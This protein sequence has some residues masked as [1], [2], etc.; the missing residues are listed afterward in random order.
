M[1]RNFFSSLNAHLHGLHE[2]LLCE[3][4]FMTVIALD[5]FHV[6][7][8]SEDDYQRSKNDQILSFILASFYF[9]FLNSILITI[10]FGSLT[11]IF[12]RFFSNASFVLILLASLIITGYFIRSFNIYLLP[13]DKFWIKF[14]TGLLLVINLVCILLWIWR[15]RKINSRRENENA[16][17]KYLFQSTN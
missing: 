16:E 14:K 1:F 3:T 10:K 6:L 9:M 15:K 8:L 12:H 7:H 17:A 2:F 4:A 13:A 5:V 11:T